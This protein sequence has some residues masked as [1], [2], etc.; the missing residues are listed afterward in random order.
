MTHRKLPSTASVAHPV[1][2]AKL[3]APSA[4][5]NRDAI[6]DAMRAFVP[7]QGKALEIAS[8]TGEHVVR[9]AAAFPALVWQP[10][11][12]ET[13]RLASITAWSAESGLP[14]I[15]PAK[16]LDATVSGWAA[17]HSGQDLIN[18]S[19]L[20]HL[21]SEHEVQV[22][23]SQA[24]LALASAGVFLVYGPFLRG[25]EFASE[26]DREFHESLRGKDADIGYKSFQDIQSMQKQAGL[27][28]L[29]PVEMPSNNML[30]VARKP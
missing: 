8:G 13:A 9:Y 3:H 20:L 23:V 10:T 11:D 25:T 2:G 12:I 29:E 18:L 24:A 21:I 15:R 17:D 14:N 30:L 28:P 19:N 5:R 27:V 22:L 6:A 7:T 1:D 4:M 26:S 16:L